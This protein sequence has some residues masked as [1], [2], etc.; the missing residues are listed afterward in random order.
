M[1]LENIRNNVVAVGTST[2]LLST[3]HERNELV[4]TNTSSAA[5]II[6]LS[7]GVEAAALAGVVLQPYSVYY[8]SDTQGFSVYNG[9][10]FAISSAVSGQ[11]S[12]FER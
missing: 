3:A 4:I 7:F 2:V 11:I 1:V 8:A 10:I 6:T 5:Q 9:D 12:I